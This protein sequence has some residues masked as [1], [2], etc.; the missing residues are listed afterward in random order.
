[1]RCA[2]G[3]APRSEAATDAVGDDIVRGLKFSACL[4]GE[5][6]REVV[7]SRVLDPKGAG[8]IMSEPITAA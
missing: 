6:A 2:M 7:A 5:L 3:G 8:Q 4:P 1:M